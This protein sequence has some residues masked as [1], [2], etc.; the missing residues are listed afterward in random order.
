MQRG[1][2]KMKVLLI[3]YDNDSHISYFPLGLGYIAAALQTEGHEVK[4]YEQNIYHYPESHLINYLNT[5]H[6]DGRS[7]WMLR[8][9][10][11]CRREGSVVVC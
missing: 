5:N 10:T 3:A 4:I 8:D 11:R 6:F 7:N 2:L 9:D 1:G